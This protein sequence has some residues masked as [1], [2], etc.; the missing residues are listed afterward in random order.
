MD[1]AEKRRSGH[2]HS[3]LVVAI[4]QFDSPTDDQMNISI[5]HYSQRFGE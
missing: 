2:E 3:F 5:I 4:L 1:D